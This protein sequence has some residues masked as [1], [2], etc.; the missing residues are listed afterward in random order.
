MREAMKRWL[1]A[2][3]CHGAIPARAVT[4]AFRLFRLQ[5]V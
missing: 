3:Y 1:V 5:G 2:G 4:V